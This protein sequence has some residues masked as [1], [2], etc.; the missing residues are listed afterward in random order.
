VRDQARI[1]FLS[2]AVTNPFFGIDG[3]Q[4]TNFYSSRTIAR[5]QLLRPL[6]QFGSLTTGL[7]AGS[8][9]YNGFTA[10]FERRFSRGLMLQGNYTWSKTLEAV[11]Y[12]N[13][14]DSRPEHVVSDLDRP[15]RVVVLGMYELSFGRGRKLAS[16]AR[17]VVEHAIGGW[18]VQAV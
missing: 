4:G 9:W 14:T 18:Q 1:D 12:L 8:S 5:S 17:G 6:P 11:T 16:N 3:F 2:S 10:R 13:D 7:P 15:H